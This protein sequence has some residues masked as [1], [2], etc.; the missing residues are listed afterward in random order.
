MTFF[1]QVVTDPPENE[2]RV[3]FAFPGDSPHKIEI[4]D[5]YA[6]I[7]TIGQGNRRKESSVFGRTVAVV[8][9]QAPLQT[10]SHDHLHR[11]RILLEVQR[12][13]V[14]F[15]Q[16]P[17]VK[18]V[19]MMNVEAPPTHVRDVHVEALQG[20][21]LSFPNDVATSRVLIPDRNLGQSYAIHLLLV[22]VA[23]VPGKGVG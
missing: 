3:D 1:D 18:V 16:N 15:L 19:V 11:S 17:F 14:A 4:P 12:G 7:R 23:L 9:D 13:T 10:R 2:N 22:N 8:A 5:I 21:R 20:R 6:P